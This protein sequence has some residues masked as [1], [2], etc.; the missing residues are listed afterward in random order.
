MK[1]ILYSSKTG[2]TARYAKAL[3]E[4]T[5]VEARPLAKAGNLRGC[6]A[7]YL[8]WLRAGSIVGFARARRRCRI[9]AVCAVGMTPEDPKQRKRIEEHYHFEQTPF[10]LLPGGYAPDRIK[11]LDALIMKSFLAGL[12]KA[13]RDGKELTEEQQKM[14]QMLEQGADDSDVTLLDPVAELPFFWEGLK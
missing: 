8:G 6:E 11:G 2:F 14:L 10:F 1:L 12:S 7:V 4:R 9:A 5:G 13:K 3:S